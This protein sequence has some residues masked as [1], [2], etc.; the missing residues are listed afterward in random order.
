MCRH[1]VR[2]LVSMR[3]HRIT[4]WNQVLH[5]CFEIPH[6]SGICVFTKH[7]RRTGVAHKYIAYPRYYSRCSNNILH[8]ATEVVGTPALRGY[9][10]FLLRDH[11]RST[12]VQR[13]L[14]ES[15]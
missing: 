5:E 14:I 8:L 9:M 3:K 2:P 11:C 6:H 15:S 13:L 12:I 7:Q 1:I 10:D 4:I